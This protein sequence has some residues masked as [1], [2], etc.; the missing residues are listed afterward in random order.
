MGTGPF[1]FVEHVAG[2]HWVGARFDG[3]FLPGRPYLDGFRAITM[4]PSATISGLQGKQV[5]AD[6]RGFSPVERDLLVRNMGN[7]AHVQESNW[8]LHMDLSFNPKRKPFD[9][10]RVRQALSLAIDRWGAAKALGRISVLHDVGGAVLPGGKWGASEEELVKL[11]GFGKD[12]AAN[13]AEAKRLL[14][15]AGAENLKVTLLDRDI[16][17]YTT[18]GIYVIDQWRQ[19]G[20]QVEHQEVEL[21]SYFASLSGATFDVIVDSFTDYMDDPSTALVKFLSSNFSAISSSPFT[22]P[23]LDDLYAKQGRT[24]DIAERRSLVRQFEARTMEQCYVVPILWWHRIVVMNQSVQGWTMSPS[25]M[26]YQDLGS[27]WL[28]PA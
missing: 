6:F 10:P 7:D 28:T 15:E 16:L 23:V 20:V 17:P 4:G 22:D 3:Y 13:R 9:D 21:A 8:L 24:T 18:A 26:I 1:R 2:S 12:I 11:P 27:V 19:I 5:Q 25:H 14:K